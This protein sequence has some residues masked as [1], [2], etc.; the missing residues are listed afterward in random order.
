MCRNSAIYFRVVQPITP[1]ARTVSVVISLLIILNVVF[2]I[3]ESVQRVATNNTF[4]RCFLFLELTSA[5]VFSLEYLGR[6][7]S[8]VE[9]PQFGNRADLHL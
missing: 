5:V 6:I 4:Q 8:C 7:W 1:V 9:D 3:L 2:V